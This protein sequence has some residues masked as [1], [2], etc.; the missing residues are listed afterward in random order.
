MEGQEDVE[1]SRRKYKA[2]YTQKHPIPTVQHYRE[3]KARRRADSGEEGRGEEDDVGPSKTRTVIETYQKIRH[4]IVGGDRGDGREEYPA[5]NQNAAGQ[6]EAGDAEEEDEREDEGDEQDEEDKPDPQQAGPDSSAEV[7]DTSETVSNPD[8]KARRKEA[9]H[10]KDSRAEREV[11]DPVTHLPVMI[12]DF[13]GKDLKR[14]PSNE[15]T[16]GSTLR[17]ATGLSAK[18][19][20]EKQLAEEESEGKGVHEGM[21]RLFPPP[22]WESAKEELT[23]IFSL[24]STAGMLVV[25]GAML[26]AYPLQEVF[27]FPH[28]IKNTWIRRAYKVLYPLVAIG[29]G[30][31]ANTAV[32]GWAAYKMKDV[33]DNEVWE[34]ERRQGRKFAESQTPESTQWLNSLFASI[35]PLINPDL[36]TSLADTLEDVMQASLPKMVRMVSVE[37]IGQGS[38]A[39]RILGVRWLP[40]GAA[41]RSVTAEGKLKKPDDSQNNDRSQGQADEQEEQNVD[42]GME[43]EEGDFVNMEI[44]FAY[45]SRAASGFGMKSKSKNAH[46]YLGFYL[47]ANIKCPVWVELRGIVGVVRLRLQLTPDP[48]FFSLVTLTFLGQPKV[49]LSCI[50]LSKHSLNIM[51]FPVISNF[52]Q[53][54][55]DA[56]MA[57]YVAPKSLTLDLKDMLVGDDFKKDTIA[58]GVI[59]VRIKRAFDFK[60]GDAGIG[61]FKDGSADPYVSVGW[62][63]FG[64]PVWSTRVIL[65][66][67]HPHWEET[68]F[69]LVTPQ[70]LNVDERLR[71]QLWDSDRTTADDDLGRIEVDIKELM[72]GKE[73]SGKMWDRVDGFR[74][75]KAGQDMPGKLEWSVGYYSKTRVSDEQMAQQT[76]DPDINTVE[77]LKEK[78]NEQAE[79]KLREAKKDESRE[80]EQQKAQDFKMR[81]DQ[82][83]ISSPPL[84]EYPC[85]I[86]SIQVHQITG[87]ELEAINKNETSKKEDAS[88]EMEEGDDLPSAY[89]TIILNHQKIFRTRT[90]PKN[91]KPFFNAG[92][93]KFIRDWRNTEIHL[94]VR[95]ARVHEDDPL[96]GIVYLPLGKLFSKRSQVNHFFPLS[97]GI[98]YGRVRLSIVFRSVQ[99]QLPK[100]MLGWDYGTLEIMP[101]IKALDLPADLKKL[102]LKIRTNIAHGKAYAESELGEEGTPGFKTKNDT[103]LKLPVRKRYSSAMVVEFRSSNKMMDK[104]PAFGVLWLKDIPDEEEYSVKLPIW[105]GDLKRAE[106]NCLEEYGDRVGEVE[107]KLKF[108]DGLSGYHSGLASKDANLA[109]IME[110]LDTT[111]DNDDD[112]DEVEGSRE[113]ADGSSSSSDD[114][115]RSEDGKRG[116]VGQIKD[117]KKDAKQLHRRNRGLMQWKAPRTANWMMNKVEHGEDRLTGLFKH[118][119]RESGIETEV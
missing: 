100:N 68:A 48:P 62:A 6:A 66:D 30:W 59:V 94:A 70:E 71:V 43:A 110:V 116:T 112:V 47:P 3:E 36:F 32:K 7:K 91:S 28:S 38:E 19:K 98:G 10:S 41:A 14:V 52:V 17:S 4:G 27:G 20:D 37:D 73:S 103:S 54:A 39:L 84:E 34:A 50:P 45:R 8:P 101:E 85:G 78:V 75:L 2:P 58:R 106:A 88:D 51:D 64:K 83:V 87:L 80:I 109:D 23:R 82:M 79:Q 86:L 117:Y 11:T 13:T 115:E 108:W 12:H 69:V 92:T 81:E 5:V 16:P 56:A 104:S 49:D 55:V 40:T 99:L 118:R 95:D 9:K 15:K 1:E 44:A 67:M 35:W 74:A 24:A 63:K 42:E 25:F 57:E 90:K 22:D 119:S 93:E 72:K 29:L 97:G 76:E 53:S 113:A 33:W 114:E 31:V 111:F 46:L 21:E 107:M 77:Q 18:G 102:R 61:P 105:K 89:C 60:E 26:A 65:S 96:L